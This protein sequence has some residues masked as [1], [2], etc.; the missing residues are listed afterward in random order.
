MRLLGRVG[1]CCPK[2]GRDSSTPLQP[3]MF[4]IRKIVAE[5]FRYIMAMKRLSK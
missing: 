1:A 2:E 5:N 4:N 3:E